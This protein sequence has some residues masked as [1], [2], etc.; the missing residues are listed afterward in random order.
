[1]A[2]RDILPDELTRDQQVIVE[3]VMRQYDEDLQRDHGTYLPSGER[4]YQPKPAQDLDG[5]TDL[6]ERI[7]GEQQNIEDTPEKNRVKFLEDFPP[8]PIETEVITFGLIKRMPASMSQG[9]HFNQKVREVKP[10]IR[11]I[12]TDPSRPGY[13]VVT[14]GQKFENELALT[15]W[16]K[17]NK[18]VNRRVRWLEDTLKKW[19]WYIRYNGIDDFYFLGQDEDVLLKLDDSKNVLKGRPLR[20]YVRTERLT[21]VLEPVIRHIVVQMTLNDGL[22][23]TEG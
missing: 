22:N 16:A 19:T 11:S 9:Q 15:C 1:M 4:M 2:I 23:N 8:N 3:K 7:I 14:M 17:T 18:Q 10:H 21:S 6:L 20:Y 13:S 5:L 12:E